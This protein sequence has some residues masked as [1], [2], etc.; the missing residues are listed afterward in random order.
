MTATT[1]M[2]DGGLSAAYVTPEYRG[3]SGLREEA[4]AE[5]PAELVPGRRS[6][7][8][9]W[10]RSASGSTPMRT[11]SSSLSVVVDPGVGV[12]A[13]DLGVELDRPTRAS[14]SR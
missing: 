5:A 8:A 7:R 14:P 6:R 2:V 1:F 11:A 9:V 3:R 12:G 10:P 13:R 4:L